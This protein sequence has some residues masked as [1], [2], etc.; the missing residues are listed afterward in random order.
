M[1]QN[2]I[3]YALMTDDDDEEVYGETPQPNPLILS[4]VALY[5]VRGAISIVTDHNNPLM[6][7]RFRQ[8]SISI[9]A[10]AN[11]FVAFQAVSLG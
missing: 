10:K 4:V 1:F 5:L 2:L 8:F 3:N 9:N 6:L 7:R 11:I